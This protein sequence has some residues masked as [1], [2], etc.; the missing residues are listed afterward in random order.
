[1]IYQTMIYQTMT[2][3]RLLRLTGA[4]GW[5][6]TERLFYALYKCPSDYYEVTFYRRR[7]LL[8]GTNYE[9]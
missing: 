9:P 4:K 7:A 1:M 5:L 3:N 8:G 2:R 6:L